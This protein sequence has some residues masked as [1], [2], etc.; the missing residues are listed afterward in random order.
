MIKFENVYLKYTKKIFTLANI[1][2]LLKEEEN[3]IVFCDNDGCGTA[4]LRLIAKI[5]QTTEGKIYINNQ[6]LSELKAKNINICYYPNTPIY[7]KNKS[8]IYNIAYPL[9]VRKIF[10]KTAYFE[11]ENL[12][13]KYNLLSYKDKKTKSIPVNILFKVL[14]LRCLMR[15]ID[16][17]LIDNFFDNIENDDL[18]F[19]IDIIKGIKTKNTII[20]CHESIASHFDYKI[21]KIKN[22]IIDK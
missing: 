1:S 9:I 18:A 5:D 16:I 8:V 7:F 20:V 21:I 14:F 19:Y 17:L 15:P 22:S 2:F 12:L 13:K 3:A 4:L 10:K 11:A 6:P